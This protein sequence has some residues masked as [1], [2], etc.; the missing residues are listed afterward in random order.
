MMRNRMKGKTV[1]S[2]GKEKD[3]RRWDGREES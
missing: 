3:E 1:R 2:E